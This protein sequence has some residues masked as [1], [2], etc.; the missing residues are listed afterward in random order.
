MSAT[1]LFFLINSILFGRVLS[2]MANNDEL[3]KKYSSAIQ[4]YNIEYVYYSVFHLSEENK[5]K[6]FEL[7]YKIATC[8]L[9]SNEKGKSVASMLSGL[10]RIQKQYGIFSRESAYFMRKYLIEYYLDNSNYRLANQEF[11][12]LLIIYKKIGYM[13]NEMADM[14]RLS[15]DLYYAQKKYDEAME[16][17]RKS[18]SALV[19]QKTMD[20]ETL[21]KIVNRLAEYDSL[22]KDDNA[23]IELYTT[24]ITNLKLSGSKQDRLRAEMLITLGNLYDVQG[25]SKPAVTC[26]EEA[27]EIIKKLPRTNYLRQ[28]IATHLIQ[29]QDLY[30]KDGQF[31][32]VNEID[33]ELAKERRFSFF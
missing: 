3:S 18:Y 32:K 17:Y 28:N 2:N 25:K 16:F 24:T 7:P 27:V 30:N 29:L 13:G 14:I 21:V 19:V 11:Q 10:K 5:V 26:Y 12:N 4:L 6:Y 31:H 20:Y 33:V 22:N 1:L 15:G 8:Y 9:K 23:A